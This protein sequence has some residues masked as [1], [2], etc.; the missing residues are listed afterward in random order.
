MIRE[1]KRDEKKIT[2]ERNIYRVRE[3]NK[4]TVTHRKKYRQIESDKKKEVE[5]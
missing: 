3:I 2:G 4:K 5:K 1:I